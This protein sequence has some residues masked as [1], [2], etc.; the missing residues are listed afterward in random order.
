MI[1]TCFLVCKGRERPE[2]LSE[3]QVPEVVLAN[4]C[5]IFDAMMHHLGLASQSGGRLFDTYWL[6]ATLLGLHQNP[7][8][9]F[10][11]RALV[12]RGSEVRR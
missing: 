6:G 2:V 11:L 9:S 3:A 4:I 8:W 12:K 7:T 5:G 1:K 10:C